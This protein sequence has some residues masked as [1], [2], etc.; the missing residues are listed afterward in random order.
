MR[1]PPFD[2]AGLNI[3]R[4]LDLD[5]SEE[6]VKTTKGQVYGLWFS[7]LSTATRYLKF[8]DATVA[9]VVVGTTT[10]VITLALPGNASDSVSGVFSTPYGIYFANA[11]TIAATTGVADNDTGAPSAN[12]VVVNIFYK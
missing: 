9:N 10:P 3:F 11:I 7:N 5:E 6:A 12:D 1:Q 4:S 8:Y 2:E